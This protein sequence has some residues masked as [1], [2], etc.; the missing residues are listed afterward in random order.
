MELKLPLKKPEVIDSIRYDLK[1][2]ESEIATL[3]LPA[4]NSFGD[5]TDALFWWCVEVLKVGG[6]ITG[7]GYNLLNILIFIILQPALIILFFG[8]WWIERNK[9]NERKAGVLKF[10]DW[11]QKD[12]I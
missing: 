10:L 5:A 12:A 1:E 8:L 7:L 6:D 9:N 2:V 11:R 3:L 4:G